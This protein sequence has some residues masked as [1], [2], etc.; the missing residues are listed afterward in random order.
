MI[1]FRYHVVSI[2]AIFLALATGIAL[3]AGPLGDEISG[4]LVNEAER[5]RAEKEELRTDLEQAAAVSEYNDEFSEAVAP[6]VLDNRLGTHSVMLMTL[7]G[8]D[9]DTVDALGAAVERAG[10]TVAGEVGISEELLDPANR[11]TA[12]SLATQVLAGTE[13]TP[14]LQDATSYEIV[15]FAVGRGL[16][17]TVPGGSGLDA[18]SQEIRSAFE[19]SGFLSYEGEP[20]TR[21]SLLLVV[22]GSPQDIPEAGVDELTSSL[23][24]AMDSVAVGT[25][26]AGPT[27]AA[28]AGGAVSAVRDNEAAD[29]VSTVDVAQIAAGQVA[30][31]LALAQQAIDETGQYGVGDGADDSV[32]EIAAPEPGAAGEG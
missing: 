25:V 17:T 2:V 11:T 30:T 10:G 5:D 21:G 18:K 23:V 6:T 29:T 20:S 19:G 12:Q 3:G 1:D 22:A 8:A 15:G 14:S 13:G 4:G 27:E 32:P 16:L 28:E 9:A 7:P 24:G 31:M 26:V